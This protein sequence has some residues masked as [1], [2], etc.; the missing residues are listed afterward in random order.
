MGYI[1]AHIDFV[2]TL[3]KS[4]EFHVGDALKVTF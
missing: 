2:L 4:T 1:N 3:S